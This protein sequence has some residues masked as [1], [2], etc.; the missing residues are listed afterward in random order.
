[1]VFV[2]CPGGGG[3]R[4]AILCELVRFFL[5]HVTCL[6][7]NPLQKLVFGQEGLSGLKDPRGLAD[8]SP[9][10]RGGGN[11]TLAVNLQCCVS[12]REVGT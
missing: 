1:M 11:G 5:M 4:G 10:T 9:G 7:F 6:S 3:G 2:P 12:G 8:G